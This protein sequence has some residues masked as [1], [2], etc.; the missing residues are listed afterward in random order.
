MDGSRTQIQ[1]SSHLLSLFEEFTV[2]LAHQDETLRPV[3]D[4]IP[5]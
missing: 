4:A 1:T 3:S 2:K 5:A